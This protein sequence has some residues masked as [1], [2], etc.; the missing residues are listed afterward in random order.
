MW[1][2]S[3]AM[4]VMHGGAYVALKTGSRW[5]TGPLAS[6]AMRALAMVVLFV[7]AGLWVAMGID[8][9]QLAGMSRMMVRRTPC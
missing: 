7:L 8:G 6:R 3:V 9:Y 1:A 4:L 2:G 5:P